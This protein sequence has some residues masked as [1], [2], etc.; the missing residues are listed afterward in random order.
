MNCDPDL[1]WTLVQQS[2]ESVDKNDA[3]CDHIESCVRCQNTLAELGGDATTWDD[4]RQMLTDVDE[5]SGSAQSQWQPHMPIDLSFLEPSG[6]PEMLGRIGRYDVES[7]LGRGGMGVV[8]RAYDSELH[9]SVAL[10]VMA[11]EW[12]ASA[13]ARQRFAREAQSAASVAHENVIPIYNVQADADLPFLVMQFIPGCTLQRWVKANAPLDVA[14]I[15]RVAS[16]LA[17]GLAA[18]H[19]R[20]LV[21]RD[22]KPANVMVG[23]NTDRVWITDFGLARAADSMTLTQ[24]GVIA[25][26]P[27]YMSPQQARG[28]PIDQRSDLFSLGCVF[29]FLCTGRPPLDADN[30]L[31]VL[32]RIVSDDPIALTEQRDDLPPSLVSL[33]HQLLDRNA[34]QRPSDCDAIIQ[35][36]GMAQ[37]EY[38]AGKTARPPINPF[39]QRAA[40]TAAAITASVTIVGWCIKQYTKNRPSISIV[41]PP[42]LVDQLPTSAPTQSFI[43]PYAQKASERIERQLVIGTADFQSHVE[44]CDAEI[45]RL[46][47]NEKSVLKSQVF[48]DNRNW[49]KKVAEIEASIQGLR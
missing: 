8:F 29:Y 10:K 28:E 19:R 32:H 41:Q 4:A 18:A 42:S 30:T 46:M 38:S 21:H 37:H 5:P 20:G 49:N 33:I 27:H 3:I 12:A 22:I 2:D 1:L 34:E 14:T 25:G 6:H 9:R 23:E 45:D 48:F 44:R 24:T 36:L 43:D 15:L 17:E 39:I 35:R 13:T 26:T 40:L 16:Q 7:V 47:K 11:P 31:A